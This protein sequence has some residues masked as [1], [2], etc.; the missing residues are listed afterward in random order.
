MKNPFSGGWFQKVPGKDDLNNEKEE[1]KIRIARRSTDSPSEKKD[2]FSRLPSLSSYE[3]EGTSSILQVAPP[4]F[5]VVSKFPAAAMARLLLGATVAL[6]VLNQKHLLPRPLSAVVSKALFWPT[7]PITASKRWGKK[8]FTPI[9]DTII[10]GGAPFG[11]LGLPER[12]YEDYG[13]SEEVFSFSLSLSLSL[14]CLW[15]SHSP[16]FFYFSTYNTGSRGH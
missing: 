3:Y 2:T 1:E 6:Y 13:V 7:L 14:S 12:L 16:A 9:D 8:W 5:G 10:V 11:F 15:P 4:V